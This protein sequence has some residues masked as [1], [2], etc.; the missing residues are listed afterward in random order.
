[1]CWIETGGNLMNVGLKLSF[2]L[3]LLILLSGCVEKKVDTTES[4]QYCILDNNGKCVKDI[5]N[6]VMN[7]DTDRSRDCN[8]HDRYSEYG[9]EICIKNITPTNNTIYIERGADSELTTYFTQIDGNK[10]IY[11]SHD[12]PDLQKNHQYAIVELIQDGY[13]HGPSKLIRAIEINSYC[14]KCSVG[15]NGITPMGFC[16]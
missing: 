8:S 9:R 11:N 12:L 6:E 16:G 4:P 15:S 1:M 7:M 10:Y 5:T 2:I 3:V 13:C 14:D